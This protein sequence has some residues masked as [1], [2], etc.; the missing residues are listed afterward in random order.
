MQRKIKF[1]FYDKKRKWLMDVI[2]IDWEKGI[3]ICEYYGHIWVSLIEQGD[4]LQNI[5]RRDKYRKEI[6]DGDIVKVFDEFGENPN[7]FKVAYQERQWVI[8]PLSEKMNG[9]Y[10]GDKEVEVIGN[11]YKNPELLRETPQNTS[12]TDKEKAHIED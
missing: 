12:R 1:K 6:Y 8:S 10:V 4:L 9:L 7:L 2:A 3:V 11:I 5:G